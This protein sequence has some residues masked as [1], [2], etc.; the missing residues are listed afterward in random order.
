MLSVNYAGLTPKSRHCKRSPLA[1][2]FCLVPCDRRYTGF[3]RVS[4][5]LVKDTPLFRHPV[6]L[7]PFRDHGLAEG[8]SFAEYTNC[9]ISALCFSRSA[10]CCSFIFW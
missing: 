3:E 9:R 6:C 10:N 1:G 2:S 5:R 8:L 4:D 7:R